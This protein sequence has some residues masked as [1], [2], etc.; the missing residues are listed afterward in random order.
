MDIQ[1]PKQLH[2]YYGDIVRIIFIVGAI[3]ILIGLPQMTELFRLPIILP[4]FAIALLGI[5]AGI[6]NPV[7]KFS[8]RLN[9]VVSILFL[10]V[11]AYT[12]WYSYKTNIGGGVAFA[13]QLLAILFL[14]ASYFSIKSLRGKNVPEI[15]E[16]RKKIDFS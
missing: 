10:I 14:V 11:F 7:Q 3:F 2:H 15:E 8:L 12:G 13:N 1:Q 5:S 9:I 4:I 6:T 16:P